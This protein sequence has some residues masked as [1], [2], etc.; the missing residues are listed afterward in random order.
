LHSLTSVLIAILGYAI[1]NIIMAHKLGGVSSFSSVPFYTVIVCVGAFGIG[2]AWAATGH[3]INSWDA[4]HV[5]WLIALGIVLMISDIAYVGS[6]NLPGA[7]VPMITT[8][9][10]ILPVTVAIIEKL[11]ITKSMPSLRTG[12]AFLLAI[13]VVWLV[14][15]DPANKPAP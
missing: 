1:G 7:S 3:T 15:Y 2:K 10:A 12:A 6:F 9:A 13:F 14:A 11:F 4:S 8:T 5:P